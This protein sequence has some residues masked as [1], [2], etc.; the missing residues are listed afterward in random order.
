MPKFEPKKPDFVAIQARA[1]E[2]ADQ[3]WDSIIAQTIALAGT[4]APE[5]DAP[6]VRPHYRELVDAY[7][8]Q[9][10]NADIERQVAEAVKPFNE[11]RERLISQLHECKTEIAELQKARR[12][13]LQN[14]EKPSTENSGQIVAL[15]G[16]LEALESLIA[17][18]TG[19]I[20][21]FRVPEMNQHLSSV[22][23]RLA[24]VRKNVAN[25]IFT[26]YAAALEVALIKMWGKSAEN[27]ALPVIHLSRP[28]R[29]IADGRPISIAMGLLP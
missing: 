26:H 17:D 13:A 20:N 18:T 8:T 27:S 28:M 16:D 5:K 24:G 15:T 4:P 7:A 10:E 19:E 14:G 1:T 22:A 6:N 29:A 25:H 21:S 11:K 12:E 2:L 23:Q 9:L 3:F